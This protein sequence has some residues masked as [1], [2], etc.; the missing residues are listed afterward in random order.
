MYMLP[1]KKRGLLD[2]L[3]EERFPDLFED[4]DNL[5]IPCSKD[6]MKTDIIEKENYT[7]FKIDVPG[8]KK[9]DIKIKLDENGY[10]TID[11]SNSK[12]EETKDDKG[13]Y[14]RKERYEGKFSR[15]FYVG[16]SVKSE[17]IKAKFADGTLTIKLP[18]ND[19]RQSNENLINIE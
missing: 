6:V 18:K 16:K 4:W 13:N 15:S 1:Y 8:I 19:T 3:N 17:D 14:I 9:E 5:V 10:L 11:A 7:E 12:S 2:Y